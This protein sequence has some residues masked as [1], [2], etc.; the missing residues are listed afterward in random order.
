MAKET[1][2]DHHSKFSQRAG[3]VIQKE[4]QNVITGLGELLKAFVKS[5]A[6]VTRKKLQKYNLHVATPGKEGFAIQQ[7]H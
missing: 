4:V 7:E 1:K 3:H 5:H 6:S 2:T